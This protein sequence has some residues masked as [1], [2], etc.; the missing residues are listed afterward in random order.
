MFMLE[1]D[2]IVVAIV[3]EVE[4]CVRRMLNVTATVGIGCRMQGGAGVHI[5]TNIL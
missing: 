4:M 3:K 1:L 5:S 2:K